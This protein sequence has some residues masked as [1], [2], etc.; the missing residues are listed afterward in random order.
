MYLGVDKTYHR[1][2]QLYYGITE[3]DVE[4]VRKA[5]NV[6]NQAAPPKAKK[7]AIKP[8]I[9]TGMMDELVVDLM[10]FTKELDGEM[11]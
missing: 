1:V 10:D 2:Q 5:C 3:A 7:L 4:W 11:N 9:P 6:C 8:I